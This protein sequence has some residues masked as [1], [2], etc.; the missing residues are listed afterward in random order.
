MLKIRFNVKFLPEIILSIVHQTEKKSPDSTA[1][2]GSGPTKLSSFPAT[3]DSIIPAV[4]MV[5]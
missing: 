4:A 2:S 3:P 1:D 5:V